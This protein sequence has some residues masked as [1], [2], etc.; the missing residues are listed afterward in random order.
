M[1]AL[2]VALVERAFILQANGLN[3]GFE[4]EG[5]C[6][7]TEQTPLITGGSLGEHRY[8]SLNGPPW[9]LVQVGD[10]LEDITGYAGRYGEIGADLSL[11]AALKRGAVHE[12][13]LQELRYFPKKRVRPHLTLGDK[14]RFLQ[15]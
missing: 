10:R 1:R 5:A 9:L 14:R 15:E 11:K 12:N 6:L 4:P 8:L 2:R 13:A 7:E 3:V